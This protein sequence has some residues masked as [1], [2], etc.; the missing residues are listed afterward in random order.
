MIK[1][2]HLRSS[3]DPGGTETVML[4]LFNLEQGSI[5]LY[6]M[7]L[8][9]GI[10]NA[11]LKSKNNIA[12]ERFRKSKTDLTIVP[13]VIRY[14]KK[15][16]IKIVHT[17]QPIE[18]VYGA[19]VKLLMPSIK[20]YHSIHLYNPKNDWIFYLE[21]FLLRFTYKTFVM[22]ESLKKKLEDRKFSK[23]LDVLY[24][25]VL[26]EKIEKEEAKKKE[27]K[28]EQ[29][30]NYSPSDKV[31]GMI[32][33]FVQEKDQAT[34][35]RAYIRYL[36]KKDPLF[37]LVLIGNKTEL[38]DNSYAE[39]GSDQDN[40]NVFFTGSLDNASH[41]LKYFKIFVMSSTAETFGN[42]IFE[43]LLKKVPV[44]ASD[45]DVFKETSNNG[46]Y[47]TLFKTGD[48]SD[49]ADKII[50]QLEEIDSVK[51]QEKLNESYKYT[52]DNFSFEKYL[53]NLV[54]QYTS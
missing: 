14:L 28:F 38:I 50:N 44:I 48:A 11:R 17:H 10:Y 39:L 53:R 49:L 22:S 32:G 46:K 7:I 20:L 1:V 41:Y 42:V 4:R 47:F 6:Y 9:E 2:L 15:H 13:F 54:D 45:I 18:L 24:N 40:E 43:A 25:A 35:V 12:I 51:Y 16:Q 27:Q 3:F 21:K 33:N 8:S 34:V 52:L 31:I 19:L 26:T 30:I 37:K 36:R 23:K 29:L 5:K